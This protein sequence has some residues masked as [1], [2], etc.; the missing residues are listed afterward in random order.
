MAVI[1]SDFDITLCPTCGKI[2]YLGDSE[3]DNP[4]FRKTDISIGV[5]S[6]NN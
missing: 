1:L 3:N 6:D 4:V 5:N 2:I